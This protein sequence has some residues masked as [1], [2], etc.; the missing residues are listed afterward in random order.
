MKYRIFRSN[1][2]LSNVLVPTVP[3][4]LAIEK[5]MTIMDL[6]RSSWGKMQIGDRFGS[7]QERKLK[8]HMAGT[9]WQWKH[10]QMA[11]AA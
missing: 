2:E 5:D 7:K 4:V 6:F 3:D 9:C 8:G 11:E 1:V 10:F